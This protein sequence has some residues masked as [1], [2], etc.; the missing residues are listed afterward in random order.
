ML[1]LD[2]GQE[3]AAALARNKLRTGLTAFGVFWG[4]FLLVVMLGSGRGVENGVNQDYAGEAT[5]SFYVWCNRSTKPYRGLPVGRSISM[6]NDDVAA[7]RQ[8]VPAVAVIAPR[9]QLGGY[10]GGNN[11]TRGVRS[12]AFS[13]NGDVPDLVKTQAKRITR[14][15]FLNPLD[16]DEERKVAVIGTR[17]AEILFAKDEEP[18]GQG[19]RINGIEFKVVGVF[20]PVRAGDDGDRDG[21]TIHVPFSTFQRAFNASNRVGWLAV[22]SRDGVPASVAEAR[23]LELLKSRH[24][25]AP[26]DLRAFGH[27]NVEDEYERLV[28]L[29]AGIRLLVWIVGVGTLAAGVIGVSNIMLVIVKERTKEIGI[30]RAVGAAP[31]AIVSQVLMEAMLLTSCAGYVGLMAGMGALELTR[32]LLVGSSTRM[33]VN[34]DV[35][36]ATA[37]QALAV[38]VVSGSL[39]GLLPAQRA[40]R[41]NPVEA[42]RAS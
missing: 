31:A 17:V 22:T 26:D 42:L 38:L 41:I 11:V 25:V 15:R 28:K 18:V 36:L 6:T 12:G 34:P 8:G 40:I 27:W 33:F 10:G 29:F 13:V 5:N 32:A 30:R 37:L 21:Q 9:L 14:G 20:R 16:L 23:T 4:M 24:S 19:I 3:I 2:H 1:D 39:A 35:D 7:V